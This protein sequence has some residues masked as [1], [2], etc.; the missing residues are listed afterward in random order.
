MRPLWTPDQDTAPLPGALPWLLTVLLLVFALALWSSPPHA[1]GSCPGVAP[2]PGAVC[3]NGGWLPS[4]HPLAQQAQTPVPPP[5]TTATQPGHLEWGPGTYIGITE[6]IP[7]AN[8][9]LRIRPRTGEPD[10]SF[11]ATWSGAGKVFTAPA[12]YQG[13]IAIIE[14]LGSL[15]FPLFNLPATMAVDD[16]TVVGHPGQDCVRLQA[17]SVELHRPF[18]QGCDTAL[19]V[20]RAVGVRVEGGTLAGRVR[21]LWLDG[22]EPGMNLQGGGETDL[23]ITTFSMRGTRVTGA[24]ESG[25]RIEHGRAITLAELRVEGNPGAAVLAWPDWRDDVQAV[26]LR[27]SW[28]ERNGQGIVDPRHLVSVQGGGA[29]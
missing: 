4:T 20:V 17:H 21:G 2:F 12:S 7:L 13:P 1:Q 14:S 15:I 10:A 25:I 6:E 8:L 22:T 16:L 18:F 5:P 27:D 24:A 19:R 9:P 3:V 23:S 26:V 29:W 28:Q 11:R